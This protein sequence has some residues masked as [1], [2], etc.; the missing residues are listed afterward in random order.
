MHKMAKD[1]VH[2]HVHTEYSLLDGLSKVN[3]LVQHVKGL[4]MDTL[5]ITEHG[6]M[7][8]VIEF[9]KVLKKEL[10]FEDEKM[11]GLLKGI[12]RNLVDQIESRVKEF[13]LSRES[14]QK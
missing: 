13:D 14:L 10:G 7:Y 5:A 9:Y 4:G 12:E 3:P 6:A 8:G 2:L 1:F 11:N